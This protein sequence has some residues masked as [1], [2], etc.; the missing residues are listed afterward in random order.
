MIRVL[1]VVFLPVLA[2]L[3]LAIEVKT[4]ATAPNGLAFAASITDDCVK[5]LEGQFDR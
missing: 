3:L 5:I 2:L 4:G 1:S